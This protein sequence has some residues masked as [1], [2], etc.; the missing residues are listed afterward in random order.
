MPESIDSPN[1]R[2]TELHPF[3]PDVA[4]TPF[5]QKSP[6]QKR[7]PDSKIKA[8]IPSDCLKWSHLMD[9]YQELSTEIDYTEDMEAKFELQLASI[10][11]RK[12][13]LKEVQQETE[14]MLTE[15]Q[16]SQQNNSTVPSNPT[17]RSTTLPVG[18]RSTLSS[19]GLSTRSRS[20]TM[21]TL[22][23]GFEGSSIPL[24]PKAAPVTAATAMRDINP[25]E[26]LGPNTTNFYFPNM[27]TMFLGASAFQEG[28]LITVSSDS[29]ESLDDATAL[30]ELTTVFGVPK[31]SSKILHNCVDDVEDDDCF[32][33]SPAPYDDS[34]GPE[35]LM[36]S[37]TS[38]ASALMDR[39]LKYSENRR[40]V[41]ST[42]CENLETYIAEMEISNIQA[43]GDEDQSMVAPS[44]E[45]CLGEN[46]AVPLHSQLHHSRMVTKPLETRESNGISR[47]GDTDT[48]IA[49]GAESDSDVESLKSEIYVLR[50]KVQRLVNFTPGQLPSRKF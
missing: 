26:F 17:S 22:P 31:P 18:S 49:S 39:F 15:G 1:S 6:A 3:Q 42:D 5:L 13:L 2:V 30:E 19:P 44:V 9:K 45:T 27:P 40:K 8:Q 24:E 14:S 35:K 7:S 32:E 43:A 12:N 37:A 48:A 47:P 29:S 11:A 4:Q 20:S 23:P 21:S 46:T 50:T 16:I 33:N 10:R 28:Q 25:L 34:E 38:D 36:Q 41:D